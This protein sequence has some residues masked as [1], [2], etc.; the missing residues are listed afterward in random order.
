MVRTRL[1]VC[2]L[3]VAAG[4]ATPAVVDARPGKVVRVERRGSTMGHIPRVCTMSITDPAAGAAGMLTYCFGPAVDVGERIIA[5]SEDGQGMVLR[6]AA[7]SAYQ[8]QQCIAPTIWQIT[9]EIMESTSVT[10]SSS[11]RYYGLIDGGLSMSH[12]KV[13]QNLPPADGQANAGE[14]TISFDQDGDGTAEFELDSFTCNDAGVADPSGGVSCWDVF[15]GAHG[16]LRHVRMDK[17]KV[18]P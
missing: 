18:C 4:A 10:P 8:G 17:W 9:P 7:V 14:S 6:V 2:A 13:M 3:A 11:G 12:S 16:A 1:V 15:T 5:V